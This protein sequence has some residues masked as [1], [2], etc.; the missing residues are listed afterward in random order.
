MT[1]FC[2]RS[3]SVLPGDRSLHL[4]LLR[5]GEALRRVEIRLHK[6]R[7]TLIGKDSPL[8][9]LSPLLPHRRRLGFMTRSPK[10]LQV[11]PAIRPQKAITIPRKESW[12]RTKTNRREFQTLQR[13]FCSSWIRRSSLS[14]LPLH[15]R[16]I[17]TTI[18]M[19]QPAP[20]IQIRAQSLLR[21]ET[22]SRRVSLS[23]LRRLCRHLRLISSSDRILI[24]RGSLH[25]RL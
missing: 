16:E 12:P 10:N 23:R 3:S 20:T 18:P 21:S 14:H 7:W 5:L 8:L 4:H 1:P 19:H 25:R 6:C 15:T 9:H 22:Q 11:C 24:P 2:R 13:E 17:S